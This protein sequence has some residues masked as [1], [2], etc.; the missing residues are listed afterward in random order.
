MTNEKKNLQVIVET[1]RPDRHNPNCGQ[2]KLR[3]PFPKH[4]TIHVKP[5]KRVQ[6]NKY[7]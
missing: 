6:Y 1:N 5:T 2:E 7:A 4:K 3:Y